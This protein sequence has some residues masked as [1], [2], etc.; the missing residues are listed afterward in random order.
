M[1]KWLQRRFDLWN[2]HITLPNGTSIP[3]RQLTIPACGTCNS[4]VLSPLERRVEDGSA[5]ESDIWKWANKIHYGL[6]HKHKFLDWDRKN[7]GYKL[8]SVIKQDDPLE[9]DRHFLHSVGG[10]FRTEPDPFGTVYRF[11]FAAPQDFAFAHI[12]ASNSVCVSLGAVGYVVF[13]LDGQALKRDVA[14]SDLYRRCPK[15]RKEDMLFFFAQCLEHL[16]RHQLGQNIVMTEGLLLR[17]GSTV[18]HDVKPVDK[19][20][21]R[22]ICRALGLEWVDTEPDL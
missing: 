9:R 10:H 4:T 18:V 8:G 2:Q 21:F 12:I 22:M 7:P 13:V 15:A 16:A 19:G 14:T 1:P 11:D 5:T 20:R 17:L 6:G 3:Y